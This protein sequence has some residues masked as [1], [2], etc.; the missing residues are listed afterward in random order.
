M[1]VGEKVVQV[2]IPLQ[3][4]GIAEA[5]ALENLIGYIIPKACSVIVSLLF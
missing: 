4:N 2:A 3:I 1:R 5:P